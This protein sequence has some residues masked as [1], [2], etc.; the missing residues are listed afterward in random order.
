MKIRLQL[1]VPNR[2][3]P[4]TPGLQGKWFIHYAGVGVGVGVT[5]AVKCESGTFFGIFTQVVLEG[6]NKSSEF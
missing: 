2:L 3:D 5:P 4:A 6:H 1:K